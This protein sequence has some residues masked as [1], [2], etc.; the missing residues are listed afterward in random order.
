MNSPQ[1]LYEDA[2]IVVV[3][4]PSGIGVVSGRNDDDALAARLGLLVCH[5]LD[6]GTS[7]ALVLARTAL[8]QRTISEA[9]AEA[10]VEKTYLAL[11]QG[12]LPDSGLVEVPL[13]DWKRGRVQI[14]RGRNA[15]T[16]FEVARRNGSRLRV[17]A[18][19]HT[20]RTH[21]IRAHL[22]WSGAPIVGDEDYGGPP[23]TRIFLHA[24]R[25]ALPWPSTGDRLEVSAP[26]PAGF[27]T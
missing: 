19:P 24:L 5:R 4:K 13:G 16:R 2:H 9:F 22:A 20:G 26:E 23:S 14:G 21:Q 10:K 6:V 18:F 15:I 12:T 27:D 3:D 7:G 8:G 25:V 1:V 11:C 17:Y